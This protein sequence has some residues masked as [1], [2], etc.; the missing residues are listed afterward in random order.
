[1]KVLTISLNLGDD[2]VRVVTESEGSR[3]DVGVDYDNGISALT[4]DVLRQVL[5]EVALF[6]WEQAVRK[7]LDV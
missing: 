6:S 2:M 5:G 1:M 7:L 3:R 4:K